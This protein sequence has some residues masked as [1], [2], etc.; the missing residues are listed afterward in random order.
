MKLNGWQR[1][2]VVVSV[3][4]ALFTTYVA[5]EYVPTEAE[6]DSSYNWRRDWITPERIAGDR[7]VAKS[8]GRPS[9]KTS[10]AEEVEQKKYELNREYEDSLKALPVDQR[11][12]FLRIVIAWIVFCGVIYLAGWT[13]G[14]IIRGF[15]KST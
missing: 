4:A 12:F 8:L 9:P 1:L 2:W 7:E 5:I 3:L 6:I 11:I 10:I 15:K 14:W 13:V